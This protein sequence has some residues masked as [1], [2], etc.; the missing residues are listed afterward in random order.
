MSVDILVTVRGNGSLYRYVLYCVRGNEIPDT[1][2]SHTAVG[3][4]LEHG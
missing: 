2:T 4:K 3:P 1:T